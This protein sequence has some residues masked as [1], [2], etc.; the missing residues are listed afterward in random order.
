M[1]LKSGG[2]VRSGGDRLC[3]TSP[4]PR[5]PDGDKNQNQDLSLRIA[6]P[7][8]CLKRGGGSN[9][10]KETMVANQNPDGSSLFPHFAAVASGANPA[11]ASKLKSPHL[12]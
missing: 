12:S 3:Q 1:G 5:S 7:L 9:M 2:P 8:A 10:K 6:T 11:S 4:I